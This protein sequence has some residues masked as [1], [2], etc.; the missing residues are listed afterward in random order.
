[1]KGIHNC[2]SL[3]CS[4]N[5]DE[6][7]KH[8]SLMHYKNIYV[9]ALTIFASPLLGQIMWAKIHFDTCYPFIKSTRG[10]LPTILT[11]N[12]LHKSLWYGLNVWF[13]HLVLNH[14]IYMKNM[15]NISNSYYISPI[16]AM[17]FMNMIVTVLIHVCI[18][19]RH[20]INLKTYT[21][22]F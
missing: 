22:N 12:V 20:W 14:I 21:E 17:T 1:M 13:P 5:T 19:C 6:Y 9:D 7:L 16:V 15:V 10:N 4:K 8:N 2:E 3:K 11:W 18:E